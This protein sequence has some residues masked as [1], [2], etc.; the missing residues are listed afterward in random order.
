MVCIYI[1]RCI[2]T[3]RLLECCAL[4]VGRW[5]R[6]RAAQAKP[7]VNGSD[8]VASGCVVLSVAGEP[9][10]DLRSFS[11]NPSGWYSDGESPFVLLAVHETEP[12]VMAQATVS[13]HC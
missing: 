4:S 5:N 7:C 9:L 13:M 11:T 3:Y 8:A 2:Y 10:P 1:A 6:R 12:G